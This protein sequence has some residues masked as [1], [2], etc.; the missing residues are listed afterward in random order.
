MIYCTHISLF[1]NALSITPNDVALGP[2][3][4]SGV[5]LQA[6]IEAV[7][8]ET[9]KA[10]RDELKKNLPA[11]TI[12]GTFTKRS[13]AGLEKYNGLLC[14]D[15]DA[16]DNPGMDP[17]QIKNILKEYAE[18]TFAML[19]VGGK[20]VFAI[21]QTNNTDPAQHG[22]IVDFMRLV[23]IEAGLLIDISC[24][25]VCRLRFVSYDPE[26]Y[27]NPKP[28]IFDAV[29]WIEQQRQAAR[30]PQR[31]DATTGQPGYTR[32]R[33]EQ[34]VAAIESGCN[35][36]TNSYRNWLLIGLALASEFGHDG[37]NYFHRVS[38][39]HPKYD[40]AATE[41]KYAELVRNGSGRVRIGTFFKLCQE[42]G[43]R[44]Q[45]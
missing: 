41:K 30:K 2:F 8:A 5:K 20:G 32:T 35:D 12:S 27:V 40:Y 9:D 6:E 34:F 33:V 11:A 7:R 44:L 23:F 17:D 28:A 37:E 29:R 3:L 16:A 38:Q 18:I 19:S 25:D 15:F 10:K 13:L 22:R 14:I 1:K 31:S 36:V 21:I 43:I 39:F 45:R 26:P 42:A 4:Y 24:K